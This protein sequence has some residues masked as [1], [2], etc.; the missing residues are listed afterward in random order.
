ADG[1]IDVL[2]VLVTPV[3]VAAVTFEGDT[4]LRERALRRRLRIRPGDVLDA[5]RIDE[6]KKA[7]SSVYRDRG[8]IGSSVSIEQR[9]TGQQ[10]AERRVE[11]VVRLDPGHRATLGEPRFEGSLGP[12]EVAELIAALDLEPG[13]RFTPDRLAEA[14]TRLRGE[15]IDRGH[16]SARVTAPRLELDDADGLVTP[17]FVVDVGP[18]VELVIRGVERRWL[19]RRDLLPFSAERPLDPALLDRT[20]TR[21]LDVLQRRGHYQ[22]RVSCRIETTEGGRDASGRRLRIRRLII[23]VDRGPLFEVADVRFAG[24]LAVPE[25]ELAPLVRIGSRRFL[26]P[27]SGRLVRS[28]LAEDLENLRAFYRLRGHLDVEVEPARIVD[29]GS[30]RLTVEIPITA[31]PRLR[32]VDLHLDGVDSLD[33]E[34][35]RARLPLRPGGGFHPVLLEDSLN[36]LRTLYEEEGYPRATVEPTLDWSD[37]DQLVEITLRV[38]EGVRRQLDRLILRGLH[39]TR[40]DLVRLYADLEPGDVVSRRRL[41]RAE[42]DL[43]RLGIFSEVDIDLAAAPGHE[44]A[45]DV[46]VRLEEGQ[47]WRV[48]YGLSYHSDDGIGGLLGVTRNNLRGRGDRFQF[49]WRASPNDQRVRWIYDQPAPFGVEL[50]LT[51]TLFS[52]VETR[53]SYEVEESGVRVSFTRDTDRRRWGLVYDYRLVEQLTEVLDPNAVEREDTEVEIAS[54][55]PNLFVDRRDDPLDPTRGWSAAAQLEWAFP[56]FDADTELVKLFGQTTGYADLGEWG[57]LAASFRLGAIEPGGDGTRIDPLLPGDLPSSQVPISERFFAGGRTT[58][59]AFERDQLGRVDE[60]L[61]P[62]I[63]GSVVE[64]GGNGLMLINVDYRFPILGELGGVA[65]FDLGNVWADWQ[66]LDLSEMRPGAGVGLRY[67]SPVGPIRFEI[68]WKLDRE[69]FEDDAPVFFF[70]FGNPF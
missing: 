62:R 68:G 69:P 43:F 19:E 44:G 8:F 31:G 22:A 49:D 64:A 5:R 54:L 3:R 52:R 34:T 42:R 65:F 50:P 66:D 26:V 2:L 15:L 67:R 18:P 12:F 39:R 40:A 30:G 33:P 11:L 14:T 1:T 53:E 28:E 51:Y 24:E 38:E 58:H 16:L 13:G 59:R 25:A 4:G 55:A 56:L 36:V 29:V 6:T 21:L 37:D 9:P 48:A 27:G 61:I 23:D 47:R 45:R 20:R 17:T 70:S 10:P 60:T 41:L 63:D 32:V 7:L 57:V 35:L 46:V